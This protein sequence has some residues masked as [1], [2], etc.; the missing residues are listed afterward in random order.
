MI[1]KNDTIFPSDLTDLSD[2]LVVKNPNAQA[3]ELFNL[4]DNNVVSKKSTEDVN[5]LNF[6]AIIFYN[7]KRTIR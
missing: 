5:R 6:T 7:R 2:L 4:G 1:P 3:T